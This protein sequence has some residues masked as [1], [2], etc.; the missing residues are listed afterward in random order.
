VA[1]NFPILQKVHTGQGAQQDF[2]SVDTGALFRGKA[3]GA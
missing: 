3:S 1:R 2:R